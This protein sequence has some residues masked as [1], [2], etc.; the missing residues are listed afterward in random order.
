MAFWPAPIPYKFLIHAIKARAPMKRSCQTILN[1]AQSWRGMVFRGVPVD[2]P[3]TKIPV[4]ACLQRMRLTVAWVRP[5]QPTIAICRQ[6]LQASARTSCLIPLGVGQ[7][8]IRTISESWEKYPIF[9]RIC[10]SAKAALGLWVYVY[11]LYKVTY[12]STWH[13]IQSFRH[14]K[15]L[16][17]YQRISVSWMDPLSTFN[18]R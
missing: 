16:L 18:T 12:I 8:I 11:C 13:L 5:T 17:E 14:M 3:G 6:P 15:H 9:I 1:K 7:G 2:L 10:H 4:A